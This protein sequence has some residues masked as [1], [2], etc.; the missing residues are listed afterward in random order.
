PTIGRDGFALLEAVRGPDTPVW[1]RELPSVQ[2]LRTAWVQQ[3]YRTRTENGTE[4]TRR[5]SKDL[6]PGRV[7]LASPYN[8]DARYGVNRES[9]CEGYKVHIT[10]TCDDPDA[11]TTPHVI[12]DV[13]AQT[14]RSP[15]RRS[16][17]LCM[18]A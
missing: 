9:G 18:N 16:P 3:Y 2:I 10:E 12:T 7:R 13:V 1:L 5:A 6:P 4:A 11:S 8:L 17:R 14:P 15:F